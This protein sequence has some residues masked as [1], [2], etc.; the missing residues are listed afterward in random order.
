MNS[1]TCLSEFGTK[2]SRECTDSILNLFHSLN[3][4]AIEIR[5]D[6]EVTRYFLFTQGHT[7]RSTK[8]I[9]NNPVQASKLLLFAIKSKSRTVFMLQILPNRG[10]TILSDPHGRNCIGREYL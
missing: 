9:R 2:K 7:L 5:R 8:K 10:S 6:E 4:F 3:V 1:K